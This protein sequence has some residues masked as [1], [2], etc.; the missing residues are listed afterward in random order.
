MILPFQQTA[1]SPQAIGAL[2]TQCLVLEVETWPKPGLVSHIDNGSHDDMD[3]G[4]LRTSARV[5]EPFFVALAQAG[6]EGAGM[7]RLRAI[8]MRAE[9]AM[10]LA[11]GGVNTHRG[12][13]FGLGLLCAAA[14]RRALDPQPA[15]TL[16]AIVRDVWG[17]A[18]RSGPVALHSHGSGA[19]RRHAATG[20]RGEATAG[21]LSV[22]GIGVPALRLGRH[23]AQSDAEAARVQAMFALVARVEDT[24]LLHRGG[25][26]GLGFA[27]ETAQAFLDAGG[28]GAPGWRAEAAKAHAAFVARRLSPGGAADLLALSLFVDAL[29]DRVSERD[30]PACHE[31]RVTSTVRC[32]NEPKPASRAR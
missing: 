13:I 10:L 6:R 20:A 32:D 4:L 7:D 3:A 5:L 22:Y 15:M 16:G 27:Q 26:L 28:V 14:G 12:A 11:T 25:A 8:G 21:F 17:E 2:A 30:R 19:L 1:P 31:R 29:E 23:D 24:N 9:R 18:I